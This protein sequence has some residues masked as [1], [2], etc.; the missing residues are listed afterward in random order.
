[1]ATARLLEELDKLDEA[2]LETRVRDA[3]SMLEAEKVK[4]TS[5]RK[6]LEEEKKKSIMERES[7][8]GKA[9]IQAQ[10]GQSVVEKHHVSQ[11][12]RRSSFWMLNTVAGG[13]SI[14]LASL[15]KSRYG[16]HGQTVG[17]YGRGQGA[18][19]YHCVHG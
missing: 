15:G 5:V 12:D 8:L 17:P 9:F 18:V 14:R 3:E 6:E 7:Q 1:M 11:I 4:T 10:H 2:Q 13:N 16:K 19:G